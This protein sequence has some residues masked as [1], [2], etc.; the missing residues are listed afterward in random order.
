MN[1]LCRLGA[2]LFNIQTRI[3][4][5]LNI[6]SIFMK[7]EWSLSYLCQKSL[8]KSELFFRSDF[9]SSQK[10]GDFVFDNGKHIE[11]VVCSLVEGTS[12]SKWQRRFEQANHLY[13]KGWARRSIWIMGTVEIWFPTCWWHQKSNSTILEF[14]VLNKSQ[15]ALKKPFLMVH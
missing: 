10:L 15:R 12:V 4:T 3:N 8:G 1:T 14:K 13:T 7:L 9:A 6:Y 2:E 5:Y 11:W